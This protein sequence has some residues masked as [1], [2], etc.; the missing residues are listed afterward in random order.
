MTFTTGTEFDANTLKLLSKATPVF[1][2]T[3]NEVLIGSQGLDF[4]F[5]GTGFGNYDAQGHAQSGTIT[6]FQIGHGERFVGELIGVNM[7]AA[8]FW[9][10]VKTGN[11]DILN[12]DIFR[13][14]D[15]FDVTGSLPGSP[16]NVY[17]GYTGN[18]VFHLNLSL[19]GASAVLNGGAGDDTFNLDK[20]FDAAT[21]KVDGGTGFDVINLTGG[22]AADL[23]MGATSIVNVER[24]VLANGAS[25]TI[26]MNDGNVA[27]G[28]TL[29]VDAS[30]TE[31]F[32]VFNG[33]AERDGSFSVTGGSSNDVLTG[34]RGADTLSGGVASNPFIGNDGTDQLTGGQGADHFT[35]TGQFAH[36]TITDFTAA[37]AGHDVIQLSSTEFAT[38]AA[39]QADMAQ[40]GAD[41]VI[42][43]D[44]NDSITLQHVTLGSLTAADFL[45][46]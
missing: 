28:Q 18:D 16:P 8:Q 42:T 38:F 1:F 25:Y 41:V 5:S 14:D 7:S 37:G 21:D 15:K 35:F 33:Q 9:A 20:N 13:G 3:T 27:A 24:I 4:L 43:L 45:F 26:T 10:D 44:A 39:V 19:H 34:G 40:V 17:N 32:L 29:Q 36:D 30:A 6:D 2:G 22:S 11:P 46:A 31:G 23:T 12:A